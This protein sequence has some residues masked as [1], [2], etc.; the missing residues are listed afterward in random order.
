MS[1]QPPFQEKANWKGRIKEKM[2][3]FIQR[4]QK[5]D[6]KP[7]QTL[8]GMLHDQWNKRV[9]GKVG[10][11]NFAKLKTSDGYTLNSDNLNLIAVF[12]AILLVTYIGADLTALTI[13]TYIPE[14]PGSRNLRSGDS[15]RKIKTIADFQM[16]ISRNLFNSRGLI[17]GDEV[18]VTPGDQNN[19]PIRTTLPLTLIGTVILRNELRSIAT[20]EDKDAQNVFP[21]RVDD[22]IPGKAKIISI[23]PYKVIFINPNSGRRE[24]VDIPEDLNAN[25][26]TLGNTSKATS[27]PLGAGIEQT[28]ANQFNLPRAEVDRAVADLNKVLTE[29]RAIPHTEN[30]VAAG[31]KL[32]QIVPG[33]IYDKLGLKNGDVLSGLN[34]E[35]IND[36]GKA[37]EMLNQLKTQS[38]MELSVKR[39]GKTS[40]FVYDIR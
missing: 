4:G 6:G 22:E 2:T 13:E 19:A 10:G 23:E 32:I 40:N 34:G 38:R 5:N 1:D 3:S 39:D 36:P 16:I 9:G 12:I 24:F 26:M 11:F 21:V 17:P 30:G 7:E 29:A 14:A 37:W 35:P 31:Y 25:P 33:S 8:T 18:P 28:S 15:G 20:I 27:A